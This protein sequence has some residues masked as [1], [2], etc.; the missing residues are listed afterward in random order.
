MSDIKGNMTVWLGIPLNPLGEMHIYDFISGNQEDHELSRMEAQAR[1]T[2]MQRQIAA[3]II[4]SLIFMRNFSVA[5]NTLKFQPKSLSV[6]CSIFVSLLGVGLFI[7]SSLSGLVI[8][9]NCRQA[10]WYAM[11][12]LCLS[13][14]ANGIILLHKAYL[15]LLRKR[16]VAIT[17]MI[18]VLLQIGFMV[19]AFKAAP[20][21]I[22]AELAVHV[23]Y[24]QYKTFG[25]D[26]WRR[27]TEDG[28]QTMCL[29]VLCNVICGC[30]IAF[31][32]IGKN[33]EI[34]FIID[35]VFT[36]TILVNHCFVISKT[37]KAFTEAKSQSKGGNS[38][39]RDI[40][41]TITT[42]HGHIP[43][44]TNFTSFY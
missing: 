28:I 20:V 43:G 22:E 8:N 16:W 15:A 36:S 23:A 40:N 31:K 1:L 12:A 29:V 6:W 34:F 44:T 30:F 37:A 39:R 2:S 38:T 13:T 24:K 11:S 18:F 17:G 27:L 33:S 5:I 35:W 14:I 19:V 10:S 26:A 25:S 7:C 42:Y 41:E 9:I 4:I 21:T 32:L 3:Y